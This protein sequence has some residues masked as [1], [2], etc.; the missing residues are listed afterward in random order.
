L[1]QAEVRRRSSVRAGDLH[2]GRRLRVTMLRTAGLLLVLIIVIGACGGSARQRD[3]AA[4]AGGNDA[5]GGDAAGGNGGTGGAV[6]APV[7]SPADAP[8]DGVPCGDK[9]C[10]SGQVCCAACDGS[11]SCLAGPTCGVPVVSQNQ[12]AS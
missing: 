1:L 9:M 10:G 2:G 5:A 8:A 6:D 12:I 4:G 3:G 7:E 11:K